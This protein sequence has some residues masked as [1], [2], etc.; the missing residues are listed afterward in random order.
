MKIECIHPWDIKPAEARAIQ[1]E[2]ARRVVL[3]DRFSLVRTVCGV[4]ISFKNNIARAACVILRFPGF[5][6]VECSIHLSPVK[7]PYV[8]GLLSFREIP[9]LLPALEKLKVDPDLLLVDGQG[10]AHPRRFGLASHL[11]L[12]SDKPTVG[13][14]KSRLLGIFRE[15]GVEKG[16]MEY[17]YDGDE[18]IGVA[19]RTR[20]NV[21]PVFVS[22]GHNISLHSAVRFVLDCCTM[23]RTPEPIR[24]AHLVAGG[25]VLKLR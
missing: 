18:I 19:L 16:S 24:L 4:D 22:V 2:L 23:Y 13:C 21:K 20:D 14:A 1:R 25:Q 8:P 10:Y 3:E 12:I 11:G 17:L 6:P 9:A 7:F 5:E 15:P